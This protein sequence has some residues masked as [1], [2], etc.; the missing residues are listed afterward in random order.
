MKVLETYASVSGQKVNHQKSCSLS[1]G[2]FP[3]MRKRIVGEI[4]R[5]QSREFPVKYLGCPLYIGRRKNCYFSEICDSI[6]GRVLSW[7]R[8]LLS[9]GGKLVLLRSVLSS[10]PI[11]LFAASTPPKSIFGML[12]KIFAIFLWGS[13]EGGPQ[14]HWIK[15]D[16]LCKSYDRGGVG[17]RSLRHVFEA[18]SMKLWWHFR[19]RQ[20]LWAEFMH[21]KYCPNSHPCFADVSPG[22]SWT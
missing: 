2:K 11:H 19:L 20:S 7:K 4:T 17:L 21:C 5:F 10:I 16:R 12:E 14:F 8:R 9:H 6:V 15:R 3:R 18:F 13:S 22:S 1:H